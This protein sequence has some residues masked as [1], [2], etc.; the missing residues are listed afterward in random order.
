MIPKGGV[1]MTVVTVKAPKF[2]VPIL[3]KIFHIK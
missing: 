2:T 3:K 1:V